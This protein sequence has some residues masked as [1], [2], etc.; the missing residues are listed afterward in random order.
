V[1]EDH[2]L[3]AD[4]VIAVSVWLHPELERTVTIN[5]SGMITYP[6]LGEIR[7]AGLTPRQLGDPLAERLGGFL[8]QTPAVRVTV[9]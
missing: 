5:G 6:P 2:V 1:A 7:A 8:R 4:D 3:G 9:T